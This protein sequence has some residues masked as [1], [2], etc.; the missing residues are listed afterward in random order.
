MDI[1]ISTT[2]LQNKLTRLEKAVFFVYN[3]KFYPYSTSLVLDSP[4]TPQKSYFVGIPWLRLRLNSEWQYSC[5]VER[6]ETQSKH[7][8][9]CLCK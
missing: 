9:L 2:L 3:Q 7:L 8:P 4:F 5:H 1:N 6:S